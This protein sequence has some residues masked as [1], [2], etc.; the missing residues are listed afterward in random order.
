LG[1]AEEGESKPYANGRD[2]CDKTHYGMD[3]GYGRRMSKTGPGTQREN[4]TVLA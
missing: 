1:I 4:R 2:N 3:F